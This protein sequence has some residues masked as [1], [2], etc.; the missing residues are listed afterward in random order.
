[1]LDISDCVRDGVSFALV[2]GAPFR[3]LRREYSCPYGLDYRQVRF[4]RNDTT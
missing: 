4:G 3:S 2:Y 1:M